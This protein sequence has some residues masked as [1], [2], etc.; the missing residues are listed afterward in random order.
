MGSDN[1]LPSLVGAQ[2]ESPEG[3]KISESWKEIFEREYL[4][5]LTPFPSSRELVERMHRDGYKL[6]VASSAEKQMLD[7]LLDLLGIKPYLEEE[8]SSADAKNSKP[9]PDIVQVALE[10]LG[11]AANEVVMLGDTPYDI[12]SAGKLRIGTIALRCGGW[13]DKDLA[14][15]LAIY[16]DPAALL[17]QYDESP[18]GGGNHS[19]RR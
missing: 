14:D 15:A 4:P 9:A 3:K 13:Q 10:R 5:G 16:D 2:K 7:Q 8:T 11:L 18:L 1:L 17:A 6:A 12:E 19:L